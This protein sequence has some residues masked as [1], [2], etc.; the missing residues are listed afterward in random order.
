LLLLPMLLIV[1]LLI[2]E[3]AQAQGGG[4]VTIVNGQDDWGAIC[5]NQMLNY[6]APFGFAFSPVI[7]ASGP[8]QYK[9]HNWTQNTFTDQGCSWRMNPGAGVEDSNAYIAPVAYLDDLAPTASKVR[10]SFYARVFPY[11]PQLQNHSA[12]VNIGLADQNYEVDFQGEIVNPTT[13]WQFYSFEY[14]ISD[15]PGA[16]KFTAVQLRIDVFALWPDNLLID[17]ISRGLSLLL[18]R[19]RFLRGGAL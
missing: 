10:V 14:D 18:L 7:P 13:N 2:S 15:V 12:V 6:S 3:K 11:P 16:T 1:G 8:S 19:R 4:W 5:D 17:Q 9:E